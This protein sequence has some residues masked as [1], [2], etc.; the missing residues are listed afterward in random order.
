MQQCTKTTADT[1]KW[2]HSKDITHHRT[3]LKPTQRVHYMVVTST[4]SKMSDRAVQYRAVQY[5][6]VQRSTVQYR[7]VQ[8][9]TIQYRGVQYSTVQSST[10]QNWGVQYRA[11]QYRAVQY[12]QVKDTS[13]QASTVQYHQQIRYTSTLD[14]PQT[15]Q[16]NLHLHGTAYRVQSIRIMHCSHCH[17]VKH[18]LQLPYSA[19]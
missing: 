3:N 6:T 10:V 11:V 7:A 15:T 16:K 14:I 17:V 18:Y 19:Q 2:Y 8:Y 13:L 1:T 4:I 5:N 12:K 9:S